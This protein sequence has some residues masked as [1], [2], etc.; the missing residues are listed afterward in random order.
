MARRVRLYVTTRDLVHGQRTS[1]TTRPD[2]P[3]TESSPGWHRPVIVSSWCGHWVD[4][5]VCGSQLLQPRRRT[6]PWL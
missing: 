6:N 1:S 3:P 4:V 2:S 5:P